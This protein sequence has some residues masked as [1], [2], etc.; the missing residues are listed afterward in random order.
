LRLW[1]RRQSTDP[2]LGR[3]QV[4]A[5]RPDDPSDPSSRA[6][7]VVSVMVGMA[8]PLLPCFTQPREIFS[9]CSRSTFVLLR[10]RDAVSISE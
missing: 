10:T 2:V 8:A 6:V 1:F 7:N 9:G 4:T 5:V 3:K